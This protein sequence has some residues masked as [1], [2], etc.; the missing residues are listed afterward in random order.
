MQT[1]LESHIELTPSLDAEKI[2]AID[3]LTIVIGSPRIHDDSPDRGW[4]VSLVILSQKMEWS[5]RKTMA[6][7]AR[8]HAL[9]DA[10]AAERIPDMTL[11]MLKNDMKRSIPLLKAASAAKLHSN[12]KDYY[13]NIKVLL[14]YAAAGTSHAAGQDVCLSTIH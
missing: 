12:G 10:I 3:L 13:L 5:A 2:D 7:Q 6:V 9:C 11:A 4:E 1:N 14:A 8:L